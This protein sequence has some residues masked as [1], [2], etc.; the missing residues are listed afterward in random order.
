MFKEIKSALDIE[1]VVEY[2]GIRFKKKKAICPFHHEKTP[3]FTISKKKQIF[4]CHGCDVGGDVIT[5]V[6]KMFGLKNRDAAIKLSNDFKLGIANETLTR[7]QK[8]EIKRQQLKRNKEKEKRMQE[9]EA[10]WRLWRE[11]RQ[12]EEIC[13]NN[14]PRR[15]EQPSDLWLFANDMA[16]RLHEKIL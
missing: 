4:K 7:K 10:Y 14:K 8:I 15:G 12:Y 11:Y 6:A 13:D 1:E 2:Y 3:S 5:F 9:E 16:L